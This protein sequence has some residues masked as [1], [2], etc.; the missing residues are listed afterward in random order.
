MLK[1]REPEILSGN[2]TFNGFIDCETENRGI[3]L[4]V[5]LLSNGALNITLRVYVFRSRD[6][7][8]AGVNGFVWYEFPIDRFAEYSNK[9]FCTPSVFKEA[10]YELNL[11]GTL[12]RKI[13][14]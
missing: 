1:Q 12:R 3:Q 2:T 11:Y 13:R 6:K 7:E 9:L 4:V 10:L 5:F 8:Y 14:L